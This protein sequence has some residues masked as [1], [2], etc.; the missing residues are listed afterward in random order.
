MA[1]KKNW[2]KRGNHTCRLREIESGTENKIS[3]STYVG[4]AS[5]QHMGVVFDAHSCDIAGTNSVFFAVQLGRRAMS[6]GV[7][8]N[9]RSK[10]KPPDFQDSVQLEKGPV[11]SSEQAQASC[12]GP[13]VRGCSTVRPA[14]LPRLAQYSG[15]FVRRASQESDAVRLLPH[16][17]GR[18]VCSSNLVRQQH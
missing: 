6:T 12:V 4:D 2:K 11:L 8:Y 3:E 1:I 17:R 13:R 16:P 14:S 7:C 10:A 9:A 15:N 5:V 18:A